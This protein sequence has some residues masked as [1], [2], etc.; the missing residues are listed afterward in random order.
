MAKQLVF[1]TNQQEAPCDIVR[2]DRKKLYGWKD[3]VAI[4]PDG[5]ECIRMD[6]DETGSFIIPKGGKAMGNIGENGKWVDKANLKAVD[7]TGKPAKL[8]PSTFDNPI[9]LDKTV[10]IETYLDH[11][12]DT[13][14]MITPGDDIKASLLKTIRSADG[15]LTFPFNYRPGYESKHAFLI[16]TDD[17]LYMLV[18][19]PAEFDFIGLEQISDLNVNDDADE[20][21]SIEDDL[22]FGSM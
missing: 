21:F 16:E 9:Q 3:I 4:G 19:M 8:I 6:I 20:D 17:V 22:D 5:N 2:L 18:G 15:I 12:I 7:S 10:D 1:Q 13:V 11:V 14:Y